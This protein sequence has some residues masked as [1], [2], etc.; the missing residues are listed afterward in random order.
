MKKISKIIAIFAIVAIMVSTFAISAFAAK[1]TV[2]DFRKSVVY[3]ETEFKY[4]ATNSDLVIT[5]AVESKTLQFCVKT[6][7]NFCLSI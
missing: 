2:E 3:I 1:D 5:G 6:H 4:P 7:T